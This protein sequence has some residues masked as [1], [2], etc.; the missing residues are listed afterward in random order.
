M[1]TPASQNDQILIV[2][3]DDENR[4]FLCALLEADGF[5]VATA[6]DGKEALDWLSGNP[7]PS[8]VLLDL[9]MP[10]MN[11]WEFLQAA[12]AAAALA[13]IRVI[14]LTGRADHLRVLEWISKP[15][16]PESLVATLRHHT[17]AQP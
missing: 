17:R 12:D 3:D 4:E 15:A 2:E 6:R 11:G 8:V 1:M 10:R 13:G 9:E 16:Q 7:R 5:L 14:M